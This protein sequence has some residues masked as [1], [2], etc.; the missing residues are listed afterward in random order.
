MVWRK[1]QLDACSLGRWYQGE[2][3][4]CPNTFKYASGYLGQ[5]REWIFATQ[6]YDHTLS[7]QSEHIIPFNTFFP[8]LSIK[9]PQ[10]RRR[11]VSPQSTMLFARLLAPLV[12]AAVTNG[13]DTMVR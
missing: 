6:R 3:D 5:A 9:C 8:R 11:Q 4:G 1:L 13:K 12:L 2:P 10:E 7:P